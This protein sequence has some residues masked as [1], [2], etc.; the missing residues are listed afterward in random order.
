MGMDVT[1]VA[2][3]RRLEP[4]RNDAEALRQDWVRVGKHLK[5]AI[6][7]YEQTKQT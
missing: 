2:G 4:R 5:D 3:T 6:Q 1:M 7:K